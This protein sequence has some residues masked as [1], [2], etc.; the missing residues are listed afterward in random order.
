MKKLYIL[1][2]W[3]VSLS[4]AHA[5]RVL[6]LAEKSTFVS[7]D[8]IAGQPLREMPYVEL[9]KPFVPKD[10]NRTATILF[11]VLDKDYK[12]YSGYNFK[13]EYKDF[14]AGIWRTYRDYEYVVEYNAGSERVMP[15]IHQLPNGYYRAWAQCLMTKSVGTEPLILDLTKDDEEPSQITILIP[16]SQTWLPEA[17]KSE[18]EQKYAKDK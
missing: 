11:H 14:E 13:L 3:L 12:P 1:T 10:P 16:Q 18:A 9:E 2:F 5:Q 6:P 7:K 15:M 17:K 8:T 4:A